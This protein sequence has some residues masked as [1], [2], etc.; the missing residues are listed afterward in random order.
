MSAGER[1]ST[2]KVV[3]GVVRGVGRSPKELRK[4][5]CGYLQGEHSK[6][7]WDKGTDLEFGVCL[8]VWE[9]EQGGRW[10]RN[11]EGVVGNEVGSGNDAR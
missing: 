6:G 5:A 3:N 1:D 2:G 4:Q 10:D 8:G 11:R 9:E 7:A